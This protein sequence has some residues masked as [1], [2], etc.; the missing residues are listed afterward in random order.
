MEGEN[1]FLIRCGAPLQNGG[2]TAREAAKSQ[3]N[4]ML[5]YQHYTDTAY[6]SLWYFILP[7]ETH[8]VKWKTGDT[9]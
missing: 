2:V 9:I 8:F 1:R 3:A 4:Q 5:W 6:G 7:Y